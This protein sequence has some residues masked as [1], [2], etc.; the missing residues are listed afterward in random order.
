L[1]SSAIVLGRHDVAGVMIAHALFLCGMA[2]IG[3]RLHLGGLYYLALA[4][5]AALIVYQYRLIR[6][7]SRSGCF[8][9]FRNNNWV[10]LV[11]FAGV[12]LDLQFRVG[13]P[14]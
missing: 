3:Y 14:R 1:K 2:V 8:A 11:L 9:A 5:A 10:G 12:A 4:A 7:R 6:G 13:V